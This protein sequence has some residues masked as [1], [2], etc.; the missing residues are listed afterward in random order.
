LNS[1]AY[2]RSAKYEV[3]G[4]NSIRATTDSIGASQ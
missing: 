3:T 1:A 2:E 4:H